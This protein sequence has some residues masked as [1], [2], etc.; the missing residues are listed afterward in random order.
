MWSGD[1]PVLLYSA[2]SQLQALGAIHRRR[3]SQLIAH[4]KNLNRQCGQVT[5]GGVH[6]TTFP[7]DYTV[8][9]NASTLR[10]VRTHR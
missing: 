7:P 3:R 6:Y 9:F 1:L 8:N 4:V 2:I 5:L 10:K